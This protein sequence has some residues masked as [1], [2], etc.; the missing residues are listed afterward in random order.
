L[1]GLTCSMHITDN[2]SGDT[3]LDEA[4]A[5]LVHCSTLIMICLPFVANRTIDAA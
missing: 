5:L 2:Q 3:R 4:H 1:Q